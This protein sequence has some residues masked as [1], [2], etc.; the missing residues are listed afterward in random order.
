MPRLWYW[1]KNP[2]MGQQNRTEGP[3]ID[4][5]NYSQLIFD[6]G[7]KSVQQKNDSLFNKL[8][9]NNWTQIAKKKKEKNPDT[10][11]HKNELKWILELNV[12][13]KTIKLEVYV[14]KIWMTLDVTMSFQKEHEKHSP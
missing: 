8:C 6:K 9:W 13:Y 2:H 14:E 10:A 12:K 11:I 3:E 5:P 4:P 7:E 1:R